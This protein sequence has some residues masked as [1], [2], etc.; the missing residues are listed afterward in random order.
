MTGLAVSPP[1]AAILERL[2]PPLL[3]TWG[4]WRGRLRL[5]VAPD[6]GPPTA[7]FTSWNRGQCEPRRSGCR[8]AVCATDAAA[9]RT[10]M[11]EERTSC[12]VDF[13]EF[14]S[15]CRPRTVATAARF[16]RHGASRAALQLPC[17][18]SCPF[19]A[20]C[21]QFAG[22]GHAE[23]RSARRY[24]P[25]RNLKFP[26]PGGYGLFGCREANNQV[27]HRPL[28]KKS[29]TG[30]VSFFNRRKSGQGLAREERRR[31][32]RTCYFPLF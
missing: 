28:P 24:G 7:P 21:A 20:R 22:S 26:G 12:K 25:F 2:G 16:D 19:A 14:R 27:P 1:A 13:C 15:S 23:R 17:E 30:T 3:Q 6:A 11:T 10:R 18:E 31:R 5:F 32:D 9:R 29:L 8:C 4:E